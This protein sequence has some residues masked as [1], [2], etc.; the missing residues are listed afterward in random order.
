MGIHSLT[1]FS[2][3]EPLENQERLEPDIEIRGKGVSTY[4]EDEV[5]VSDAGSPALRPVGHY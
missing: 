1:A 3:S 4:P 5:I 2:T